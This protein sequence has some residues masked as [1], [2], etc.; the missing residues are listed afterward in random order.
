M[1]SRRAWVVE[2][3]AAEL[4][5]ADAY[6]QQTTR[7]AMGV[8]ASDVAEG[9]DTR[10]DA[11][12]PTLGAQAEIAVAKLLGIVAPLDVTTYQRPDLPSPPGASFA[13]WSI[14]AQRSTSLDM[15]NRYLRLRA[16]SLHP[17]WRHALVERDVATGGS[18][19][20]VVHGWIADE[21]VRE[22][23]RELYAYSSNIFVH[24]R[25]LQSFEPLAQLDETHWAGR[26]ERWLDVYD[27]AHGAPTDE[28]PAP[29]PF[30]ADREDE[31]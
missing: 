22:V 9:R 6:G 13:G 10:D 17:R 24:L 7:R 26:A 29:A 31:R 20:F 28:P 16:N 30:D 19:V 1:T 21:R 25:H 14:K 11:E 5:R 27:T 12:R 23:G 8:D 2:L 18:F 15:R 3:N 4:A